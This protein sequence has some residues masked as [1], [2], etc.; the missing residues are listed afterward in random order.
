MSH[1]R[2]T[3]VVAP[4]MEGLSLKRQLLLLGIKST[5]GKTAL[6]VAEGEHDNAATV[7]ELHRAMCVVERART[8]VHATL[9]PDIICARGRCREGASGSSSSSSAAAATPEAASADAT[10]AAST[11][12]SRGK[13]TPITEVD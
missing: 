13:P 7:A 3:T 6:E 5:D 9:S 2:S 8:Y 11:V 1:A 4:L 12:K 10:P